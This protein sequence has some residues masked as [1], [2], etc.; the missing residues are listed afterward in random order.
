MPSV[1]LTAAVPLVAFAFLAT[2]VS[3][4]ERG[5]LFL[6]G[7]GPQPPALVK[8][9]VDLAGGAG[10]AR[11]VVFAMA[12]EGGKES[13][14]DKAV[15][16]RELGATATSLYI[17]RKEADT[18]SIVRQLDN[19]TG[20]WF[21]GG[22]Q[23]R[24]ANVLRATK[25]AAAIQARYRAGAVIGGTSA[26]AAVIS[27]P[28]ITGDERRRGGGRYPSDSSLIF[29]TIDRD[30]VTVGDGL[31]LV[32][33]AIIDQHFVR[34][35]RHNRLLSLV[36]EK[37]VRLGAGIDESTALVVEPDGGWRVSGASVVVI[38]DATRARIAAPNAPLAAT[39]IVTHVLPAGSRFDP[40]GGVATLPHP[41]AAGPVQGV[42]LSRAAWLTGCWEARGPTTVVQESWLSPFGGV[43]QS[44]GRTMRDGQ[45][46]EGEMVLMRVDGEKLIY[47]ASPTGQARTRFTSSTI[48][49]SLL[50]FENPMHDFPKKVGYRKAG[51]DSLQAWVEG[52]G[53]RVPFSYGRIGCGSIQGRE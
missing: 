6:V 45:F 41:A 23:T 15:Q 37:P 27:T 53:R 39:G 52:N 51:A 32:T 12:S 5:T 21:G 31:D 24:L 13:G 42:T 43:M 20:I 50:V 3:G 22:D 44:V 7:G 36:L 47:E 30:N 46:L 28:M 8:E 4:Q 48:S 17:N 19:A 9:F 16:L 25:T 10:K 1:R 38:Y 35:K 18:D 2:V 26:G 14:E 29:I 49:D 11:I 40:V 34:R 33:N